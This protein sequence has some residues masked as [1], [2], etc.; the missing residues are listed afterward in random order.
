MLYTGHYD[1]L[2]NQSRYIPSLLIQKSNIPKAGKGLFASEFIENGTHLGWYYGKIYFTHP[3]NDSHYILQ[4][5][6]KPA[7]VPQDL[8]SKR[9]KGGIF[10]D[11]DLD[12]PL[13][14]L[15]HSHRANVRC[16]Q[17]GRIVAQK[18]IQSGSEL[19]LNYG[20]HFFAD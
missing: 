12:N 8:W 18:N 3:E 2:D 9:N 10:I 6:R 1:S 5:E 4:V 16:L 13:S 17:N 11:G 15:N 7:W 19:L 20:T 14:M